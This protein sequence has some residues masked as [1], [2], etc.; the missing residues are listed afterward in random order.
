MTERAWWQ[1]PLLRFGL[2]GFVVFAAATWWGGPAERGG[3]RPSLPE[4]PFVVPE[5]VRAKG[6]ADRWLDDEVLAR[7]ARELGLDRMDLV[8]RRRLAQQMRFLLAG[9]AEV[10][11]PTHDEL[12]GWLDLHPDRYRRPATI[13]LHHVF[14]SRGKHGA[15]LEADA[16]AL[17][18]QLRGGASPEGMGDTFFAGHAFEG[19]SPR[20][21][22]RSFGKSFATAVG[23]LKPD[24]WTGPVKS[25]YGLHL[26]KVEGRR[27]GRPATLA[28]VRDRVRTDLEE[29]RRRQAER[30]AL[31][32]LRAEYDLPPA[33]AR[34]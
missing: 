27:P 21:L 25:S 8:V 11:P 3:A 18:A 14:V 28:E 30:A 33:E 4:G 5:A 2:G 17:L 1:E 20:D 6:E 13:D 15:R 26:V 29:E 10:G 24:V 7:R 22:T 16:K 12:K 19:A 32:R 34:P 9:A 31:D 23:E